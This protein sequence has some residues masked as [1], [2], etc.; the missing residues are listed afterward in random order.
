MLPKGEYL[1]HLYDIGFDKPEG[2]AI[3]KDGAMYYAFYAPSF[4]GKLELRGLKAGRYR[5]RDL[6][7]EVDLGKVTRE[8]QHPERAL[9]ALPAAAGRA[10]HDD[11]FDA[12]ASRPWVVH[13]LITV[14]ALGR[15]GR[16]RG[17]VG[18]TRVP[19]HAGV[20]RL[21]ADHDSAGTVRPGAEMAGSW[22]LAARRRLRPDR[23]A[24]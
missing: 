12:G 16:A 4:N 22:N 21:G 17:P 9:R 14:V 2:H 6:F 20:L 23:R 11:C 7:N 15:L 5:V 13:A 19:R 10:A 1:G 3:S 18:A 8:V 24:C